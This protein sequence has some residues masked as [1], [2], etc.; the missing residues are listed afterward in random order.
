MTEADVLPFSTGVIGERLPVDKIVAGLERIVSQL[1]SEHW[2]LAAKGIMTT[3]TRPEDRD[4]GRLEIQ[5]KIV[6]LTGITKG[7]GMIQPNMGPR[8]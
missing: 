6:T 3:D 1:D 8:C 5:G 2:L 4:A 7:A